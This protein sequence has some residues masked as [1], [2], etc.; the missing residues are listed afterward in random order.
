MYILP[1]D[2]DQTPESPRDIHFLEDVSIDKTVINFMFQ[3]WEEV[4]AE[5][6]AYQNTSRSL[7]NHVFVLAFEYVQQKTLLPG[8]THRL[9]INTTLFDGVNKEQVL[10]VEEDRHSFFELGG[11]P[12]IEGDNNINGDNV[13]SAV[14]KIEQV[15]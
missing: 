1:E 13:K 12:I 14:I 3:V 7:E 4:D 8:L 2:W 5:V 6:Q 11:V 9:E 15:K 10:G